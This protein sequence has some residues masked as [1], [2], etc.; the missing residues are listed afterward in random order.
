VS[1]RGW[2]GALGSERW[3]GTLVGAAMLS[4]P[5]TALG[6]EPATKPSD[7]DARTLELAKKT[8]NPI[9]DLI[10]LPLQNNLNFGYGARTRP[11]PA[12]PSMCSTSSP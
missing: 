9:A 11:T 12:A 10:S 3:A 5:W 1:E 2:L 8:Q 6:Q 4:M 7:E